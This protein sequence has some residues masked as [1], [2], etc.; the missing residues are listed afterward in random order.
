MSSSDISRFLRQ[1]GKHYAGGRLQQGRILTDA[2]FN[3]GSWLGEEDRRKALADFGPR[4]S[5]D[6]GFS[7]GA[8]L[9][10]ADPPPPPPPQTPALRPGDVVPIEGVM[11]GDE[12]V[13]VRPVSIRAG[14]MHLGGMRFEMEGPQPIMFQRDFLQMTKNDLA[15]TDFAEAPLFNFYYLHA[16]EQCI[17]AVED[18]EF[19]EPALGGV[20]TS[21]RVRRMRRVEMRGNSTEHNCAEAFEGLARDLANGAAL[22]RATGELRS[23]GRLF[24]TESPGALDPDCADCNP[25]PS[26]RFL[27]AD[28]QTL[29]LMLSPRGFVWALDDGAPI[30]RAE[31]TGLDEQD[32]AEVRV[33]LLTP[34]RDQEHFPLEGRVVE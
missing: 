1:P 3:E 17:S 28:N 21:L 26:A 31:V 30:Y 29:R 10:L 11:L 7:I 9:P 20:D 16:W 14:A 27:G 33:T 19:L 12:T 8:P 2:D 15:A 18:G 24:Y 6:E 13:P 23:F 5:P 32:P 34:P 4:G 25:S 22:D